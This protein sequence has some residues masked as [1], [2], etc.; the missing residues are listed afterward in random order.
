MGKQF[1]FSIEFWIEI[2]KKIDSY[3]RLPLLYKRLIIDEKVIQWILSSYIPF[4]SAFY[5]VCYYS[6]VSVSFTRIFPHL[7]HI[8]IQW[9]WDY[10]CNCSRSQL[11]VVPL[12]SKWNVLY[13]RF[14]L[15]LYIIF[16]EYSS[17]NI[18]KCFYEVELNKSIILIY[19]VE[20]IFNILFICF[21]YINNIFLLFSIF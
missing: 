16:S 5:I 9:L 3:Q 12:S 14:S 15:F 8:S 11:F 21:L 18:E 7:G 2:I 17:R 13:R 19:I 4:N 20:Y 1:I 10:K 6:F